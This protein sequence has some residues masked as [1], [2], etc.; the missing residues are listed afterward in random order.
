[1]FGSCLWNLKIRG[2]FFGPSFKILKGLGIRRDR[3]RH[4]LT[5]ASQNFK[6]FDERMA[7]LLEVQ[8]VLI[9]LFKFMSLIGEDKFY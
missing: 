6:I 7:C 9:N 2:F 4:S 1:M 8:I 3:E 5:I